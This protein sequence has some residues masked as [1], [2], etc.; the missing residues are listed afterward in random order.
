MNVQQLCEYLNEI[1]ILEMK[2]LTNFLTNTTNLICLNNKNNP[3]NKIQSINEIFKISL[4]NHLRFYTKE[5]PLLFTLSGNIIKSFKQYSLIKKYN[6]LLFFRKILSYKILQRF[7]YFIFSVIKQYKYNNNSTIKNKNNKSNKNDLIQK[8][9][10]SINSSK[11]KEKNLK[12]YINQTNNKNNNNNNKSN[13]NTINSN[14]KCANNNN[15]DL[16]S[17]INYSPSPITKNNNLNTDVYSSNTE[18]YF[19]KNICN[20]NNNNISSLILINKIFKDPPCLKKSPSINN[21]MCI[22]QA[23]FNYGKLLINKKLCI[24]RKFEEASNKNKKFKNNK[25]E[26]KL[27]LYDDEIRQKNF[28]ILTPKVAKNLKQRAKSKEE[29]EFYKKEKQDNIL[30][31]LTEKEIDK[32]NWLDRLYRK[33]IIEMKKQQQIKNEKDKK[34]QKKPP[35]DWD[36]VYLQTN[37]KIVEGKGSKFRNELDENMKKNTCYNFRPKKLKLLEKCH[38]NNKFNIDDNI[39]NINNKNNKENKVINKIEENKI[40]N[41]PKN[42]P[43]NEDNLLSNRKS[44]KDENYLT[45]LNELAENKP[46]NEIAENNQKIPETTGFKFTSKAFADNDI[47]K[48]LSEIKKFDNIIDNKISN[49]DN[50][51]KDINK[52]ANKHINIES[53]SDYESENNLMRKSETINKNNLNNSDEIKE[54]ETQNKFSNENEINKQKEESGLPKISDNINYE[55]LFCHDGDGENMD[56]DNNNNEKNN[57]YKDVLN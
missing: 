49:E 12:T 4:F 55:D 45:D 27:K 20:N 8:K 48:K 38:I 41:D 2:D 3:Q 32:K 44:N 6:S 57:D 22:Q 33:E 50:E 46:E 43:K 5:D 56:N 51:N 40:K 25:S 16:Y 29:L 7:S 36:K 39:N 9:S 47:G 53:L 10:N 31:K 42:K 15:R 24:C 34:N 21:N 52:E 18:S 30:K 35:V 17:L 14:N 13:N 1:G 37:K 23:N 28:A 54:G 11:T 26:S 19:N